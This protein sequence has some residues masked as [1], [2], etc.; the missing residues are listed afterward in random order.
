MYINLTK[1]QALMVKEAAN[2]ELSK[3]LAN[4]SIAKMS[5]QDVKVMTE[6]KFASAAEFLQYMQSPDTDVSGNCPYFFII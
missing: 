5:D 4:S 3:T 1:Y 2:N 6:G